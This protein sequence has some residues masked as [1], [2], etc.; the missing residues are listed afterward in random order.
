MKTS[1]FFYELDDSYIAQKPT[2]PRDH[3]KLMILDKDSGNIQHK[4]F[5]QILDLLTP[6]DLLVINNTKVYPARVYVQRLDTG[7]PLEILITKIIGNKCYCLA[8]PGKK[9]RPGKKIK[10]GEFVGEC[11]GIDD[12]EKE[13]IVIFNK[14]VYDLVEKYG[15]MP[16]PPYIKREA[17][18]EDKS[19]YQTVFARRVGSAA[20][21]TAGLHFT[22][23]LI[24]KAK[25]KGVE[26]AEVT[27][28]VGIGTFRPVKVENV[29]DFEIHKELYYVDKFNGEK[30]FKAKND[31]R[32]IIAVGT[33][34]VRTLETLGGLYNLKFPIT[35]ETNIFIYPGYTFK[36]VDAIITNFH[37][38]L[39]S[40]LMLVSAFAGKDKIL[41]AY[42]VAKNEGYKFFS[43]GDA[44]F[45]Q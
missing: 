4:I 12:E 44:M 9:L 6:D 13:R 38:P 21:P 26:F 2:I 24:E 22:E 41:N 42:E 36:I 1:E 39:S 5:Y 11:I 19:T 23:D 32:R 31:G 7:S 29:E 45:I 34:A 27:L 28:H 18:E 15:K 3:C 14:S 17:F 20:A 10:I 8:K 16:L 40:L 30:I 33:T 25:D 35:G 43:Y 37:L